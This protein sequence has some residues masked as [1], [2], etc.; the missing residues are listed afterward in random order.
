[1]IMFMQESD[2]NTTVLTKELCR[3]DWVLS[4][5]SVIMYTFPRLRRV[6]VSLRLRFRNAHCPLLIALLNLLLSPPALPTA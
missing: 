5:N 4:G 1:M 6:H 2:S 3:P